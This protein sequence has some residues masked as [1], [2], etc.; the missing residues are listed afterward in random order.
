MKTQALAVAIVAALLLAVLPDICSAQ[1]DRNHDIGG[2]TIVIPAPD[3]LTSFLGLDDAVDFGARKAASLSN[4]RLLDR[5]CSPTEAKLVAVQDP[6]A[7]FEAIFDAQV[8]SRMESIKVSGAKFELIAEKYRA[9]FRP[10]ELSTNVA[11][12]LLKGTESSWKVLFGS[13]IEIDAVCNGTVNSGKDSL[14]YTAFTK[15]SVDAGDAKVCYVASAIIRL[16]GR[17]VV[18]NATD[19]TPSDHTATLEAMK[20]WVTE[21]I[22]A[23]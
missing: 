6:P 8:D 7:N 2:R 16:N 11:E 20:A 21:V 23:N 14:I 10:T 18:L 9:A 3:G 12:V 5:F 13:E 22:S 4:N 19:F 15:I 17:L 1:Q